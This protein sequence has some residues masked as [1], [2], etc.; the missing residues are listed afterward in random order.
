MDESP[1]GLR[2]L[3]VD[4]SVLVRRGIRAVLEQ[5]G[6]LTVVGEAANSHTA[7]RMADNLRPDVVLLAPAELVRAVLG[8][9][10]GEGPVEGLTRREHE[11]LV[12]IVRGQS[13]SEIAQSL[14]VGLETV[15]THVAHIFSKLR[16]ERRTQV[17]AY[18]LTRGLVLTPEPLGGPHGSEPASGR[19]VGGED[20]GDGFQKLTPRIPTGPR[21][22]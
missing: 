6:D 17:V 15:K 16:L 13:N 5:H 18:A 8:R 4:G 3:I 21:R 11:V 12:R 7:A 19:G 22:A 2:I 10:R 14:H 20:H 1:A 9:L